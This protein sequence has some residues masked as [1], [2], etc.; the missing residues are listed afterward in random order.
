M[1]FVLLK[2]HTNQV[3]MQLN[4][5]MEVPQQLGMHSTCPKEATKGW[6]RYYA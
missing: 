3:L 1:L 6:P 5:V 4:E 2:R